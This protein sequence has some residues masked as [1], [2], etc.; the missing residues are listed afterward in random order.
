MCDCIKDI[1]EL[2]DSK[3][4]NVE[5]EIG[6]NINRETGKTENRPLPLYF[7]Y[8][9]PKKDGS[10]EKKKTKSYVTFDYCPFCGCK[11]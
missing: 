11:Y 8:Q 6:F 3:Y 9:K 10:L 1:Q 7:T 4:S 5:L 2:A